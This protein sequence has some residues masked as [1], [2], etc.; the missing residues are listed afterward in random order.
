MPKLGLDRSVSDLDGPPE[1]LRGSEFPK[2]AKYI[3]FLGSVPASIHNFVSGWVMIPEYLHCYW[4]DF[5][6]TLKLASW[7]QLEQIPTIKLIFVQA[8]FVLATF[9]HIRNISTV[10]NPILIKL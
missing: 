9:V 4:T 1:T 5:D 8:T 6:E 7:E 10:T 2:L 3:E